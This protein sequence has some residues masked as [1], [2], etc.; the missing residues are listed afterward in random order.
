[1][2]KINHRALRDTAPS[3]RVPGSWSTDIPNFVAAAEHSAP[4]RPISVYGETKSRKRVRN[5]AHLHPKHHAQAKRSVK[6]TRTGME[7]CA[8]QCPGH[9]TDICSL[10][11]F[12]CSTIYYRYTYTTLS[13]RTG[14]NEN[15]AELEDET[16]ALPVGISQVPKFGENSKHIVVL[17]APVGV[18][19]WRR[20]LAV[21]RYRRGRLLVYQ[22]GYLPTH[23][24][25]CLFTYFRFQSD[26][27]VFFSE[28]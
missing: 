1:M 19:T 8:V 14:R 4:S 15:L 26:F 24:I 20:S 27:P 6:T 23:G 2:N 5:H 12:L 18:C 11:S 3:M 9:K 10:L 17:Q 21:R 16:Y 25:L 22:V 28:I 7:H 13:F